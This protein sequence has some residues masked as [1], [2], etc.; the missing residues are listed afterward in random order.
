MITFETAYILHLCNVRSFC[1]T[2]VRVKP[3]LLVL[4]LIPLL[5]GCGGL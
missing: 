2:F 4:T 1:F 5:S 3:V